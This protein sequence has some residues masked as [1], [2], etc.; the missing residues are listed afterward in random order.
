MVHKSL[1]LF[2]LLAATPSWGQN[3]GP[4]TPMSTNPATGANSQPGTTQPFGYQTP[5]ATGSA[6]RLTTAPPMMPPGAGTTGSGGTG[7]GTTVPVP[8]ATP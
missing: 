8:T 5:G 1:T 4:G 3:G 7:I 2:L 6:G